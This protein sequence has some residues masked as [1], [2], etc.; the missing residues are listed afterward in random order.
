MIWGQAKEQLQRSSAVVI[1]GYSL[2]AADERARELLFDNIPKAAAI[3]V[4]CGNDSDRIMEE[5]NAARF[6]D[7]KS[8]PIF[9]EEWVKRRAE[10]QL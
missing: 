10:A 6:E 7:V 4:V 5:F 9:F 2:P 3:E 1:C 8:C